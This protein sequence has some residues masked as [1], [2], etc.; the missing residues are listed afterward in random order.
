V[1]VAAVAG[2]V[3]LLRLSSTIME[4][5]ECH[6]ALTAR[7]MA[8]PD[9]RPWLVPA[10]EGKP[11]KDGSQTGVYEI[12]PLTWYNHWLVP[13]ENGRPRLVKTPLPY[14]TAAG[15]A[16]VYGALGNPGPIVN[17]L[18][19][20]LPSAISA[21]I[22]CLVALAI[23][24]RLFG[25]RPALLGAIMLASCVGFQRWGRDARPEMLL[26]LLT[27]ASMGCFFMGLDAGA[28]AR[29]A[30]WMAAFWVMMGLANLA[31][32]FVPLL[33]IYPLAMYLFWRQDHADC[34]DGGS[35][36]RMRT[37]LAATLAGLVV[38]VILS[39][40]APLIMDRLGLKGALATWQRVFSGKV[41]YGAMAAMIGGPALWYMATTRGWRQLWPL[42]PTAIPGV[43]VMLAMFVP[44]MLYMMHVFPG[45]AGG[46]FS[47]QVTERASGEG[48]WAVDP[49]EKYL[50]AIITFTLPWIV[51]VPGAFAS[52]LMKRFAAHRKGLVFLLLWSVGVFVLFTASAGKREHYIF[53][54]LPAVCLLMGFI[55]NDVFHEH[56]WITVAMGRAI[57]VGHGLVGL[58]GI[59][60]MAIL[61]FAQRHDPKWPHMLVVTIIAALPMVGAGW[62]AYRKRLGLVPGLLAAGFVIVY[63][64]FYMGMNKWDD[65][66]PIAEFARQAAV[67]VNTDRSLT[68]HPDIPIY[69]WGDPQAKM[70]FYFGETIP[71]AFWKFDDLAGRLR[72]QYIDACRYK[73]TGTGGRQTCDE[74]ACDQ[75]A[76]TESQRQFNQWIADNKAPWMIAYVFGYDKKSDTM[77]PTEQARRLE[78]LGYVMELGKFDTARSDKQNRAV[79][80]LYHHIGARSRPVPASPPTT[81]SQPRTAPK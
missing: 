33:L 32:E 35:L 61:C 62:F 22:M 68:G 16:K 23:G 47:E 44:W 51:F 58:A 41:Y 9:P 28:R 71:S 48:G 72:K 69:Q 46:I 45:Q 63:L 36:A 4:D 42:V 76:E 11:D 12:P 19:A 3:V 43:A 74:Q 39:Y 38:V 66:R 24:R 64:G 52:G 6:M 25:P 55:A 5:H 59:I 53:P 67:M 18:T 77:V 78:D 73:R 81:A 2:V 21:I 13:V 31:K 37:W 26:C 60:V 1:L 57:G 14:W 34:G 54:M 65:R 8:D 7:N 75:A 20:R 70:P 79:Y 30:A 80:G 29:R 27:T 40:I 49:P 15:V 56:K 10:T 17:D 50:L